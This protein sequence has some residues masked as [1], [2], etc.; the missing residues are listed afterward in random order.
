MNIQTINGIGSLKDPTKGEKAKH[1]AMVIP[2]AAGR[3]AFAQLIKW[4]IFGWGTILYYIKE[5]KVDTWNSILMRWYLYGGNPKELPSIVNTG[6]QKDIRQVAPAILNRF[7]GIKKT[8]DAAYLIKA[9]G[10]YGHTKYVGLGKIGIYGEPV[11]TTAVAGATVT[12]TPLIVTILGMIIP[13]A[14]A[15]VLSKGGGGGNP[16][17]PDTNDTNDT[18]TTETPSKINPLFIVGGLAVAGY[19]I[20]PMLKKKG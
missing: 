1:A 7:Y 2:F 9:G 16:Q 11:T 19:F 4:N 15:I 20:L 3:T 13:L 5:K 6:N 14:T 10:V 8:I 18:E 12:A 17:T